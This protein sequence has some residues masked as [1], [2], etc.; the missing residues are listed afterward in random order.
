M[1]IHV[2]YS[3]PDWSKMKGTVCRP[4]VA[5]IFAALTLEGTH[6]EPLTSF[7]TW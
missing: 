4:L 3:P 6:V 7:T 2:Q 1:I 5:L